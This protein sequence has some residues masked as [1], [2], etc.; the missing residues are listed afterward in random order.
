MSQKTTTDFR[1]QS[2]GCLLA[3]AICAC[4]TE[5]LDLQLEEETVTPDFRQWKLPVRLREISGLAL[6][7]DER[8]LSITDEIAIVYELD[9]LAGK[10]VK[11]F[12]L[13]DPMVRGDFEG[14]TV[15]D[16][17]VWLMT[18]DGRLF[19]TAEGP[20]GSNMTYSR[21]DTG[22]GDYCEFE[23]LTADKSAGTL[24]LLCK[25]A[26]KGQALKVFEVSVS[27]SEVNQIR[28]VELPEKPIEDMLDKNRVNP[29]GI[30]IDPQTGE[31]VLV[32]ARQEALIR[33]TPSGELSEA[34]I[35]KKKGRHRQPEGIEIT[36]DGRILIADE[37]GDGRAR[38]AIYAAGSQGFG[39]SE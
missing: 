29:S 25:D 3:L 18:S 27:G 5:Q 33:L 14:I 39:E 31:W 19:A 20:D 32:A 37:G 26:K 30:S 13:G 8:L 28:D 16:D 10:I 15:L 23:G 38:L 2:I 35:L 17:V 24:L 1:R 6:T 36:A 4:G 7:D 11:T 34:I 12:A 9:F 21:H 22:L